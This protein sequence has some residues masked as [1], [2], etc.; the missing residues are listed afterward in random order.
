MKEHIADMGF[1]C[2]LALIVAI[3]ATSRLLWAK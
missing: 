2:L 1:D 3:A